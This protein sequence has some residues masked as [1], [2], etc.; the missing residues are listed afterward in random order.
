[1]RVRRCCTAAA[2]RCVAARVLHASGLSRTSGASLERVAGTATTFTV[3]A[4][5][6]V[7]DLAAFLR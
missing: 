2:S 3:I 7:V 5:L 1:M 4:V 6:A